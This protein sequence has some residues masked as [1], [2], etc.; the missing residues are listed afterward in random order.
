MIIKGLAEEENIN[1][2]ANMSTS[3]PQ[4]ITQTT[5]AKKKRNLPGNPGDVIIISLIS[6]LIYNSTN[7]LPSFNS[8]F[9]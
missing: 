4:A 5:P 7:I 6:R 8:H 9:I 2:M 1:N 3:D